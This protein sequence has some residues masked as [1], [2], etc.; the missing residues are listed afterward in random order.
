M[1]RDPSLAPLSRQHQ[2]G[3]AACVLI[4]R[5]MA[6]PP[7]P[8]QLRAAA[9]RVGELFEGELRHHFDLEER[10][11]FPAVRQ[12]LEPLSLIDELIA[13]HRR[14]EDLAARVAGEAGAETLRSFTSLLSAHIRREE[15]VLFE[16]IQRRLPRPALDR[17]GA[18]IAAEAVRLCRTLPPNAPRDA[19]AGSEPPADPDRSR[20]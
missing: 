6:S 1:L 14:L 10:I 20:R 13:D 8:E 12:A 19:T 9:G 3:L 7:S 17:L 5:S 15:R 18:A 2:R 4:E 16:E 11:L